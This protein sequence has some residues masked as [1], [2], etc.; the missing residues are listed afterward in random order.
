MTPKHFSD[1]ICSYNLPKI[2]YTK[3]LWEKKRIVC[4]PFSPG[5]QEHVAQCMGNV[6]NTCIKNIQIAYC[7][8]KSVGHIVN[9][10]LGRSKLYDTELRVGI[11]NT[12][13]YCLVSK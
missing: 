12:I 2:N 8:T 1:R 5:M 7:V 6:R 10:F 3:K 4:F 13:T 9:P 11:D